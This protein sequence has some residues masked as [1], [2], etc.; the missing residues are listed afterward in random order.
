MAVVPAGYAVEVTRLMAA[1]SLAALIDARERLARVEL[2]A[3]EARRAA[4]EA[5]RA[6][7]DEEVRAY[8]ALL[9]HRVQLR[10]RLRRDA[11]RVVDAA[12]MPVRISTE[13]R[14]A[15]TD[16]LAFASALRA[17][18]RALID[19]TAEIATIGESVAVKHAELARLE[20]R[21]HALSAPS[22]IGV[23][24]LAVLRSLADEAAVA[25]AEV[26]RL[27]RGATAEDGHPSGWRR[28]LD[29][30]MTQPFGPS[31]LSLEPAAVYRGI[32]IAHFHD[33]IDIAAPLGRAVLAAAPGRVTY[34]GHLSDGAMV[35]VIAHDDGLVSLSAHLDDAFAPPPVKAG[36]RVTPGQVI[37]YVG[38]TG[39]TTGPH[40]H[41]SVHDANGPVDP[42]IVLAG[43][44]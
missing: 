1:S 9:D 7:I 40:L 42:A 3:L 12:P 29:G 41:F 44:D 5:D 32:A 22:A 6:S 16:E 19:D 36:D 21:A 10:D 2:D 38:M 8:L 30:V 14:D 20:Q 35:V 15:I 31:A 37:G 13:E 34:V 27:T 43:T 24:E 28:P 17:R 39:I 33:A 18:E 26:E 11:L 25:A 4:L 23:A